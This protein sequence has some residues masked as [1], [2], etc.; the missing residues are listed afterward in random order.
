MLD[1][2]WP[3]TWS[4]VALLSAGLLTVVCSIRLATLGDVLA[5]RTGWGEAVFG[6]VLFGLVTSLSGIVMTGVSAADSEPQLAYSNAVGGIAAQTLAV[7]IA[8]VFHRRAN[9][10]HATASLENILFG[11]LL[12][13]LLGIALMASFS[14]QVTVLGG[15]PASAVLVLFYAGGLRLMHSSELPMWRPVRTQETVPDTPQPPG[16]DNER[17]TGLLWAEFLAVALTVVLGGWA[18]THAAEGI[19]SGTGLTPGLVGAGI[20]GVINALP[21]TVTAIAAVRRG[22]VTLAIAAILGGNCLDVL[23]LV[24]GDIVYPGGSLYHAAGRDELFLTC[25][26][27]VMTTIVLGGLLVRQRR[28]WFGLGFDGTLLIGIYATTLVT[29]AF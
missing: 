23:N 14:P 21:E 12:T 20:M 1:G 18:V 2:R 3:V 16:K 26:A 5:D 24:V 4:V 25:G 7:V 8:D 28:G 15:H 9:L 13:G 10:E 6:A 27:L 29:L 19:V 22:A 11:C 17:A